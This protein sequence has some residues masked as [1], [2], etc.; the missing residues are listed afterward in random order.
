MNAYRWEDLQIGLRQSF[1]VTVTAEMLAAFA[2]LS[3][4]T[5]P[6][7]VDPDYAQRQGH[8]APVVYGLLTSSFYSRLVGVH[9]PGRLAMLQGIDV[10]FSAPAYVNDALKVVGEITFR[11]NAYKRI[12]IGASIRNASGKL[13]SKALIRV[14]VLGE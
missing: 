4:D 5:N 10:H 3:G 8:P 2:L 6:L 11:S 12:E 7:H 9:L 13:I 1:E 14:G